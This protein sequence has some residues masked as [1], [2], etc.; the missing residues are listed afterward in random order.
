[1]TR[2]IFLLKTDGRIVIDHSTSKAFFRDEDDEK[3]ETD[4]CEM[5]EEI[6]FLVQ[7]GEAT[8]V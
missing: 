2:Q 3:T 6:G 1:M 5:M 8:E 7:S 4:Y